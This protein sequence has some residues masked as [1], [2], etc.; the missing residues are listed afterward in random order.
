MPRPAFRAFIGPA[1]ARP[2]LWRL[3][4]GLIVA[5]LIYA[6]VCVAVLAPAVLRQPATDAGDTLASLVEARTPGATLLL[7]ATFAG[8]A[9]GVMVAA[10][11]LH[12]RRPGTLIGPASRALR[13]FVTAVTVVGAVYA[14]AVLVWAWRYDSLPGLDLGT[15]LPLLPLAVAGLLIQTGAEEMLFRGYLVQQLAARFRSPLIWALL[16]GVVFGLLHFDPVTAGGNA[17][18]AV[19][20]ATAFGLVAT[21]LTVVT[22]SLGAAWGFHFANNALAVLLL[23]TKGTIT[24]LALRRTPYGV[25]AEDG[26]RWLILGDIGLLVVA[27]LILR[28]ILTTR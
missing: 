14:V 20:A 8:M 26:S 10:R 4:L 15:W 28:R 2:Q 7:L 5:A 22:G 17:W 13:D 23:A 25:D 19:G 12:G 27:W 16:P 11:F 1:T 3:L 6:A 24:G 9:L 21:D 18:L